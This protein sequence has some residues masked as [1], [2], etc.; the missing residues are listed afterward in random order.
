MRRGLL[1]RARGQRGQAL[2]EMAFTLP[3]LLLVCVGI[4]EFGRAYQTWQVLTNAAREGARLSVL[5]GMDDAAVK[6]R[7]REY[8]SAGRLNKAMDAT[9]KVDVDRAQTVSIGGGATA[10]ASQVKV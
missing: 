1:R 4:L 6:D 8:M 7:V 5:P 10:P 3:L 9:V 2:L